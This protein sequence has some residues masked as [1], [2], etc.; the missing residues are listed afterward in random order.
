MRLW[1]AQF[2]RAHPS[3]VKTHPKAFIAKPQ[4]TR[5]APLL[6]P[7]PGPKGDNEAL[8][9]TAGPRSGGPGPS[10]R[11]AAASAARIAAAR[12]WPPPH[13]PGAPEPHAGCRFRVTE[14]PFSAL[15][16]PSA[17]KRRVRLPGTVSGGPRG[18][19]VRVGEGDGGG[20]W[21]RGKQRGKHAD[22][23]QSKGR[24]AAPTARE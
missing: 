1:G 6:W 21:A 3:R 12:R 22:A 16:S 15:V 14:A 8:P 18:V 23:T 7:V 17:S 4:G 20:P 19:R 2:H 24:P 9:R 5:E 11:W 13:R 10:R